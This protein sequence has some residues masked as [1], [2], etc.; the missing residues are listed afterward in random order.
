MNEGDRAGARHLHAGAASARDIEHRAGRRRLLPMFLILLTALLLFV[1]ASATGA[2][3][4]PTDATVSV[5]ISKASAVLTAAG[6]MEF[7][8]L[9]RNNGATAT[10]PLVAHLAIA[11][12]DEGRYVDPEDW[13][14]RRTQ[15]LP[16]LQPGESVQLAW[17]LRGLIEGAFVTFVTV[18]SAEESF[19]PAVSASLRLQVTPDD[20]LPLKEVIPVIAL[21]PLFPLALLIFSAAYT[22]RMER[23]RN[24]LHS[25]AQQMKS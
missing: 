16:P 14:P 21:V 3:A 24:S 2:R 20:I 13:S 4:S 8:T 22:R 25:G 1:F 23:S 6:W 9:L 5:Q 12:L 17:R 7:D 19:P 15:Y 10:P 18:V 11:A